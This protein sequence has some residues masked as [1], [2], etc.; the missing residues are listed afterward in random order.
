MSTSLLESA[1]NLLAG[2][3][4]LGR[5]RFELFG[6]ELRE[7]LARLATTILGGL[8]VLLL[9]GLGVAFGA[10]A[11]ILTVAEANRVTATVGVAVLFLLA[12]LVVAFPS[13]STAARNF[14]RRTISG[15]SDAATMI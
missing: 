15:A 3:L 14:A 9:V 12:A 6:T 7:E 11:W 10:V 13:T 2:V 8:A 4:D 5:T 1:N